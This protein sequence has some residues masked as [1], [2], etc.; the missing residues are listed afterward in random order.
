LAICGIDHGHGVVPDHERG[1]HHG[2]DHV[3]VDGDDNS[4]QKPNGS[5]LSFQKLDAYQC[6]ARILGM[7]TSSAGEVVAFVVAEQVPTKSTSFETSHL[8]ELP[9]SV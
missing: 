6:F 9:V 5:M 4:L 7:P 2:G 8:S 1:H 3:H